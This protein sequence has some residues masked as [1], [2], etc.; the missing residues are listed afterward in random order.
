VRGRWS[1][2]TLGRSGTFPAEKWI[3]LYK[4]GQAF[5]YLLLMLERSVNV[6]LLKIPLRFLDMFSRTAP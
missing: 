4:W 3:A 2:E 6:W 1:T 5:S